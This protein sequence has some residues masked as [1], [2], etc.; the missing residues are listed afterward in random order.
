MAARIEVLLRRR[1]APAPQTHLS[2]GD[3][4]LDLI[5]RTA[6]RGDTRLELLPIEFRLLEFLMRNSGQVLTRTMIF[7]SV[8]GYRF[9]PGHQCD[10]RAYRTPAPQ[11]RRGRTASTDSHCAWLRLSHRSGGAMTQIDTSSPQEAPAH[12]SE[13][14]RSST[15]RLIV[16]Y[17][18]FFLAW[19]VLLVVLIQ[20]QTSRYLETVVDEI[21]EQRIHYLSTIER[22]K[23][24][25]TLAMTGAIDLR[26]AMSFGLFDANN[27]YMAGNIDHLPEDFPA[28]G[29]VHPLPAGVQ[30]TSGEQTG[31]SRAVGLRFEDGVLILL[32]R[33]TSVI[34]RVGDLIRNALFWA[35]SLSVVP[36]LLGG[37]LLSR[38]P[39]K[40]VRRI[41]TTIA[42]IMR[43]DLGARM[44]VSGRRDELDMLASIVNR[45]LDRI[46]RLL[47]EVKGVSD[48]IAHDLRT[49]L[50]HLRAQLYRVQ[51]ESST[52][53]PR[54]PT[55][56]HCIVD[57]DSLLDRFRALL[58]ISELED[59]RRR[60]GFGAIDPG[61]ILHRVHELYLP[62]AEDKGVAFALDI[63]AALPALH[64]DGD[65][66]FEALSNLV[67]NAIKFTP[68][69]GNAALRAGK[70][71][72]GIR[73][74]IFDSGPGIPPVERE[75]VLGRF[76]RSECGRAA[77][78]YGLGLSI[79]AAIVKLH[80]YHFEIGSGEAGG[81]RMTIKCWPKPTQSD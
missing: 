31:H 17:G 69:Q 48:S 25:A 2:V 26:G 77:P 80:D 5:S 10:R 78:G 63:E 64:A 44:P 29:Q 59:I 32:S 52:T 22:E 16:I 75:A 34:E 55:I 38:G 15:A 71:P 11:G 53:D 40:R 68:Q 23:L 62:L 35:L 41:E 65:L 46:E 51:L 3:L 43:G 20:W 42:P 76:Y 8:W 21:L 27:R 60:S 72:Q 18:V 73:I 56:E 50:T 7:E 24:P 13:R 1:R 33:S 28:D 49:P 37:L 14:W 66:L 70:Q 58:R 30:R 19:M 4:D 39:L 67:D 79:V 12:I 9:D 81:S 54:T 74:D 61:E 57:V 47:G 36:G 6:Q 45:M